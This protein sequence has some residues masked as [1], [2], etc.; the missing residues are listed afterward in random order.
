MQG[1]AAWNSPVFEKAIL[2]SSSTLLAHVMAGE[3]RK[4]RAD[5]RRWAMEVARACITLAPSEAIVRVT[6]PARH[7]YLLRIMTGIGPMYA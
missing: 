5:G 2:A 6:A 1:Y 4:H 3:L 7:D